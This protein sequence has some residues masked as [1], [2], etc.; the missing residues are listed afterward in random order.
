MALST[1]DRESRTRREDAPSHY[2][3]YLNSPDWRQTRNRKL[4][5]AKYTCERCGARRDL[6]VHHR[7]YARLGA[8]LMTDLEVLCF[9]CHNGHHKVEAETNELG[10]YLKVVSAVL[11]QNPFARIPDLS[12]DVKVLCAERGIPNKPHLIHKAISMACATRLKDGKRPYTSVVET[13][14]H[15]DEPATHA[16]AV[17]LLTRLGVGRDFQ[18][19]IAKPMPKV[20]VVTQQR[21]DQLKAFAMLTREIEDSI[22]RCEALEVQRLMTDGPSSQAGRE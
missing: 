11:E 17:E 12:E 19:T 20:R 21:A 13:T 6:N 22:A 18:K 2:L 16:Q 9:T 14:P 10:I 4:R 1:E 7:T 15:H 8:E 5:E 3:A